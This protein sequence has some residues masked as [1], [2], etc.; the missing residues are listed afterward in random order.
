MKQPAKESSNQK[1]PPQGS[2]DQD[3]GRPGVWREGR[4]QR[5]GKP[6][7]ETVTQEPQAPPA[8]P[9]SRPVSEKDYEK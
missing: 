6:A 9:E 7:D 3:I 5:P 4:Y 8:K 1:Q 2:S